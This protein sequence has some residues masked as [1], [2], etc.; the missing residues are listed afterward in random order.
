MRSSDCN[1]EYSA[2]SV[3][4]LPEFRCCTSGLKPFS[5]R[6]TFVCKVK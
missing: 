6:L 4:K 2:V 1:F 3:A 5:R